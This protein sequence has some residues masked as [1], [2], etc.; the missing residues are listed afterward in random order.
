VPFES[1]LKKLTAIQPVNFKYNGKAETPEDEKEYIGLLRR[2][3]KRFF[4]N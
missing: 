1:G 3:Y 4:R 2:T